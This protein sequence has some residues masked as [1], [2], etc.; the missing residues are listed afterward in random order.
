MLIR[1]LVICGLNNAAGENGGYPKG[2]LEGFGVP[3]LASSK[4]LNKHRL[5]KLGCNLARS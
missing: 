4:L 2:A 3:T 1:I 5:L